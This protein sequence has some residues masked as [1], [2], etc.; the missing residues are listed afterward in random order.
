MKNLEI[1]IV[2]GQKELKKQ[3]KNR[4]R[5][6]HVLY[7]NQAEL[8][9]ARLKHRICLTAAVNAGSVNQDLTL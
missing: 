8:G 7:L 3:F 5:I 2:S 1:C 9:H 6:D 4:Q